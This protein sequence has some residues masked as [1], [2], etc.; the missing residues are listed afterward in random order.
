MQNFNQKYG[1][2]RSDVT[3]RNWRQRPYN[4]WSFQHVNEVVPSARIPGGTTQKVST[5]G[6]VSDLAQQYIT[7]KSDKVTIET[8]LTQSETDVFLIYQ[9]G[10]PLLNWSA[11]HYAQDA[12][13]IIFSISKSFTG[14]LAG[15]LEDLGLLNTSKPV[16]HYLP[17][18]IS[19]GFSG[20]TVQQLLDMQASVGFSEE[21]L[22]QDGDYARYRRS[23]A[24]NPIKQGQVQEGLCDFLCSLPTGT[25]PHGEKFHYLSPASDLLGLILEQVS[26]SSYAELMS[27]FLWR[28]IEA[29]NDAFVTVDAYGAPRGAGGLSVQAQDLLRL[30]ETLR[31]NGQHNNKQIISERW[32]HD[33]KTS[34]SKEAW[35]KGN[36][37]EFLPNACYR[38]KWYQLENPYKAFMA[39][40]I[41]GQWLYVIPEKEVTIVKLSSQ[42]LPQDDELDTKCLHFFEQ[43]SHIL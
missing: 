30:G 17:E 38:N 42:A 6:S 31:Q 15:Q 37:A 7:I 3:L 16:E 40:G 10:K 33:M 20:C 4:T 29:Q 36:F 35:A 43:I 19:S 5:E 21:Y 24:W 41:H 9:K 8:F 39:I 13:H 1:F 11:P 27:K 26:G 34:G 25:A 32:I 14:I 22:N 2:K 12:P 23:T 18:A 28:P